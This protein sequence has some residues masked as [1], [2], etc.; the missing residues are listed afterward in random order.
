MKSNIVSA[1]FVIMDPHP[2]SCPTIVRLGRVGFIQFNN[3]K[4]YTQLTRVFLV[5]FIFQVATAAA[6]NHNNQSPFLALSFHC[7]L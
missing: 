7:Q 1:V 2:S 6:E 5:N 4:K 3:N